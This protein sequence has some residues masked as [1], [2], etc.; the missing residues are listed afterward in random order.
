MLI[1]M[2]EE[3]AKTPSQTQKK[4]ARQTENVT[5]ECTHAWTEVGFLL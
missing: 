5:Q 1:M 3:N 4:G 2:K